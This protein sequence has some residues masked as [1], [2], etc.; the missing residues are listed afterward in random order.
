MSYN[1]WTILD[2]DDEKSV[3][4]GTSVALTAANFDAQIGLAGTYRTALE[5]I[6]RGTIKRQSLSIATDY[7][8]VAPTD[9]DAQRESKILVR[10][11]D[12]V[13][14]DIYTL[15]IAT[16]DLA[17]LTLEPQSKKFVK[18]D[19]AGIMATWVAAFEGYFKAPANPT[20][21]VTVLTA[22]VVGR[23]I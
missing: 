18:L 4:S 22:Q 3:H 5:G 16:P 14:A 8:V 7:A 21:A 17:N 6:I 20:N 23:N 11:K 19:D 10:Y 1:S 15:E 13:T 9:N 2:V 12:D